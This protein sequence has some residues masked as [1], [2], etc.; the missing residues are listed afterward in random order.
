MSSGV[1]NLTGLP[2]PGGATIVLSWDPPAM[3]SPDFYALQVDGLAVGSVAPPITQIA[4]TA[5]VPGTRYVFTIQALEAGQPPADVSI[6]MAVRSVAVQQDFAVLDT[7]SVLS[8][9]RPVGDT[10][11]LDRL[12]RSVRGYVAQGSGLPSDKVVPGNEMI[13]D[14]VLVGDADLR[15]RNAPPLPAQPYASALLID[16]AGVGHPELTAYG[17]MLGFRQLRRATYSVQFY[18]D[19]AMSLARRFDAWSRSAI[20]L[21]AELYQPFRLERMT[22]RQM[23]AIVDDEPYGR[24]GIDLVL[25]YVMAGI[26]FPDQVVEFAGTLRYDDIE[27]LI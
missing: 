19:Q 25:M 15:V 5:A 8:R 23:D 2:G 27:V 9:A 14:N 4:Y 6:T 10:S 24:A 16:D 20:G 17:D 18:G 21:D 22:V 11:G 3:G 1:R 7:A 26:E 12:A 13:A